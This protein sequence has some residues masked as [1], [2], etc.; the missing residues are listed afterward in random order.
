MFVGYTHFRRAKMRRDDQAAFRSAQSIQNS[1]GHKRAYPLFK[2]TMDYFPKFTRFLILF[3]I[4]R[5]TPRFFDPFSPL[6]LRYS[7]RISPNS[8]CS[9]SCS[10]AFG[11]LSANS[12]NSSRFR[13]CQ[14]APPSKPT[15][16]P[17]RADCG[18]CLRLNLLSR[19]FYIRT[20]SIKSFTH[21]LKS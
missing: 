19:P 5:F 14:S 6:F 13:T 3:Q 4:H 8:S 17:N 16:S 2:Q 10:H 9:A 15:L 12:L 18:C 20:M 7:S 1:E 21:W 11:I